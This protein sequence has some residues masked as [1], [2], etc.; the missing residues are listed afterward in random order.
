LRSEGAALVPALIISST[1]RTER[2]Q[3]LLS[4]LLAQ[5][6]SLKAPYLLMGEEVVSG[7]DECVPLV[8][9]IVT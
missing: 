3:A 7:I 9:P 4:S 2:P 6:E 8:G 1:I 5:F